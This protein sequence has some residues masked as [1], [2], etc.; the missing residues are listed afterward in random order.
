MIKYIS[1]HDA[2]KGS[3]QKI[4]HWIK[5]EEYHNE[6]GESFK[7][8]VDDSTRKKAIRAAAMEMAVLLPKDAVL[9]P[10][11]SHLGYATST[12]ELAT[13]ISKISKHPVLD[14]LKGDNV[15]SFEQKRRGEK[16]E[17]RFVTHEK[18]P[19]GTIVYVDNVI[20]SGA[21]AKAAIEVF[22]GIVL[23]YVAVKSAFKEKLVKVNPRMF[24]NN[25][26][27]RNVNMIKSALR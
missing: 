1:A 16:P 6:K 14:I 25:M 24:G 27:S 8:Q 10:I 15:S 4:A 7:V 26:F 11:P 9:V 21:T 18:R 5:G 2:Y 22:D 19:S 23:C 13:E 3:V 17:I 20:A 12:L